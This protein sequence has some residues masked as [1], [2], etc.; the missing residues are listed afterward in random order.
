MILSFFLF[1]VG[2]RLSIVLIHVDMDHYVHFSDQNLVISEEDKANGRI[3]MSLV[4]PRNGTWIVGTYTPHPPFIPVDV[5]CIKVSVLYIIMVKQ[6]E[7][8]M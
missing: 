3:N 8:G 6:Y 4:L 5:C 1:R 7:C 2:V